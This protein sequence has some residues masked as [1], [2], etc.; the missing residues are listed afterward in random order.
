MP[1]S[2]STFEGTRINYGLN[3]GN[4]PGGSYT[5][6]QGNLASGRYRW[7]DS[8]VVLGYLD[9]SGFN[10]ASGEVY[11]VAGVGGVTCTVAVAGATNT[12]KGGII[13]AFTGC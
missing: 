7:I 10:I 11:Q 4:P 5:D 1:A 12:V 3:N 2:K 8:G 13:T 9:A 6:W